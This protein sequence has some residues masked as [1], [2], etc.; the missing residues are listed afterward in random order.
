MY[1]S[2]IVFDKKGDKA[3]FRIVNQSSAIYRF[4]LLFLTL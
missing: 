4:C 2:S 3:K 1:Y